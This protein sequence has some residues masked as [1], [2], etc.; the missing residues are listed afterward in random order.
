VEICKLR[1]FLKLVAQVDKVKD[2]EPLPDIDFNIRPGNTLV[3]FATLHYVQRTLDGKLG[4]GKAQVDRIVKEAKDIEDLFQ[5]FHQMQTIHGMDAQEFTTAKQELRKRLRKLAAE[6]DQYLASEYRIDPGSTQA[7][8]QW[9]ENHRPFHWFAEFYGIMQQGGFDVVIGNPPWREYAVVRHTYQVRGYATELCGNLHGICTERALSL[10][11][12]IGRMSFIV[13][14]PLTSSSRMESVRSVLRQQSNSLYVI[15]FDDRPGKLFEGLEHCR[16]VIFL[17]EAPR[18][19][20]SQLFTARYQRWATQT[21]PHLFFQVEYAGVTRVGVYPGLFPKYATDAE[22]AVFAKIQEKSDTIIGNVTAKR[23]TK[24]FI[25]Y[26]EA[27]QYWV[28]ATIGLPYYAKNGVVGPPAHGRYVYFDKAQS[29]TATCAIMNS[30]LFYVYF[31]AYGDC[32][33]LSD[34]LVSGFP[35][36]GNLLADQRLVVLG[37]NLQKSLTANAEH[38]TIQTR[39]GSEIAYAE[40]FASKSKPVIDEID[41]IL[42][43]H[44][45]FTHEEL[46]FIINYDIKYRLGQDDAGDDE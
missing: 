24:H 27:T 41:G 37:E 20:E 2:L 23:P 15:P 3:G 14:L 8:D 34:T 12:R 32:F 35:I 10:R 4:F 33:H 38:K 36:S 1:L 9:H 39:D 5:L 31:I 17:S 19:S 18:S 22:V 45:G 25:F 43:E 40:F 6:L 16:G 21:R 42:A 30:S 29:V 13:Q 46:D 11:S 44:Y 28:K 26:Q 7:Y